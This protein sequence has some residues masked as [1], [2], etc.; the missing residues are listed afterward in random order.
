MF[1]LANAVKLR[2]QQ[3]IVG[4]KPVPVLFPTLLWV[5]WCCQGVFWWHVLPAL[6]PCGNGPPLQFDCSLLHLSIQ[7]VVLFSCQLPPSST[8]LCAEGFPASQPCSPFLFSSVSPGPA[9]VPSR[10]GHQPCPLGTH[11]TAKSC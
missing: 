6:L 2:Q 7:F 9:S 1:C 10:K 3:S 4:K 11:S 8:S 5:C